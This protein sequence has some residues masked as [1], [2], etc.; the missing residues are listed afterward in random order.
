MGGTAGASYVGLTTGAGFAHLGYDLT[1]A[2]VDADENRSESSRG[3]DLTLA[4]THLSW[5][6]RVALREVLERTVEWFRGE[7]G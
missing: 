6:P 3:P 5:A 2:D 4:R 1:C 7:L